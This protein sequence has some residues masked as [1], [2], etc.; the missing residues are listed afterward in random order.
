MTCVGLTSLSLSLSQDI[1][2]ESLRG[3]T[4]RALAQQS[5]IEYTPIGSLL[6]ELYIYSLLL[7]VACLICFQY[8]S[9]RLL[10]QLLYHCCDLLLD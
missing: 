8:C 7:S 4:V 10:Y 3:I 9:L 1:V 6:D 5:D 2:S